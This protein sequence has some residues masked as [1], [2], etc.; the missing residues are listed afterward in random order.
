MPWRGSSARLWRSRRCPTRTSSRSSTSER[1]TERRLRRHG[2]SGR[3][4]AAREARLG[5]DLPEAGRGLRAP[6][7]QGPLRRP[8]EGHRPPGPEARE[9]LRHE[10]RP[11]QDPRLRPGEEGRGG[12][13]RASETSAPTDSRPHGAG[14]GDGDGGLHV[15]RAGAGAAGRSPL[16]HLL[17][18]G[19][20][21][22]A[23]LGQEGIQEGHGE[24][25]RW[26]RS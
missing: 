18:R 10:R 1:R 3:R 7:C 17:L 21:L 24:P 8:R 11:R 23:A 19:D 20:P 12:R 26:R 13:P 14:D 15:A 25:T 16:G 5:S 6:G 9:P 2:A 4:D 22:R